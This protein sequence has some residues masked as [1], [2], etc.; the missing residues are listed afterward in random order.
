MLPTYKTIKGILNV[1]Y[2]MRSTYSAIEEAVAFVKT[3]GS[4]RCK[5]DR[6]SAKNSTK[7]KKSIVFLCKKVVARGG[8]QCVSRLKIVLEIAVSKTS[9]KIGPRYPYKKNP[10][11]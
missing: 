5:H 8:M 4:W 7:F 9:K 6:K 3:E 11:Q 1:R 10:K 2:Y